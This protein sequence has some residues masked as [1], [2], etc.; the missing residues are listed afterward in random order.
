M[1]NIDSHRLFTDMLAAMEAVLRGHWG[2]VRP[3]A[4]SEA[5]K[6]AI[7]A[8]QIEAGHAAGTLNNKQA[9]ILLRMQANSAQA[10]LTAVATV[11]MIA[12]QDAINAALGVLRGA[13]NTAVGI[14]LL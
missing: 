6:L 3:F 7:T 10:A 14:A 12:A 2:D 11:G 5:R 4:E 1:S 8:A 9:K 13:V